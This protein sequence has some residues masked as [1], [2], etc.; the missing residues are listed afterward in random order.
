[1]ENDMIKTESRR[2]RAALM[3][4][5][6][7]GM[8]DLVA[9]PLWVGTLIAHH[10]FDPQQA[11][12][13][14]TLFLLGAVVASLVVAPRFRLLGR[15]M[16]PTAFALAALAF[17]LASTSLRF[18]I[19]APLH[20]LGGLAVGVAL[21]MT[22]GTIGQGANPH[23][24]FGLVQLALGIFAVIFFAATPKALA[25]FGGDALFV[26]FGGL[27]LLAS[28]VTFFW[29]PTG[30]ARAS[31]GATIA[32]PL[33]RRVWFVVVGIGCMTLTQAMVF[34]FL[35]RM[36]MDRGFGAGP[37]HLL[38]IAIGLVNLVPAVLATVL[39]R[40]LNPRTVVLAGAALQAAL[41]MTITW[42]ASLW[43]YAAAA[44]VFVA[45][46][47]FTHT[48][49]FGLLAAIDPSGRAVAGT[50]AMVM[51]GAA[52]GPILAG[53]LVKTVGYPALGIA[54]VVIDLI[55][56][57]LFFQL[58]ARPREDAPAQTAGMA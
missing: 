37:V 39:Q 3:V 44:S 24:L 18:A 36:G 41:A 51:V 8:V 10:G 34:S 35:E 13:L 42:S 54:A 38:L 48:F 58:M 22:H 2:G 28:L 11:G 12:A 57:V 9:L 1:M 47:I 52:V 46:L 4:A 14:V 49:A 50:P 5:H 15:I 55:A 23:R 56:F 16:V 45:L 29:F 25:H 30:E 21:S 26:V 7:A 32:A 27:M 20:A 53:T 31:G 17:L 43:P 40:R 19:L 6:C 33:S